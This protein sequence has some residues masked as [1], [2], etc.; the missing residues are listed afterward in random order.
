MDAAEPLQPPG[1]STYEV[2]RRPGTDAELAVEFKKRK[3]V[4]WFSPQVLANTG[5]RA[6]LSSALGDFLD[7]RELQQAMEAQALAYGSEGQEV[8]I[9]FVADTGDGFDATYSIAWLTAQRQLRID[10][11]DRPLPRAGLLVLGGDEVYPAASPTEYDN[12]FKGPYK[13]SL[14]HTQ[15]D[16]PM[17]VAIPG[18]HDWY[19]GLTN[20]MRLFCSTENEWIGGRRLVQSRSYFAIRLPNRWWIWGI[21]IQFDAYI[22]DPQVQYFK[23][24]AEEMGAGARLIL[25]TAKPSWADVEGDPQAFRNLAYLETRVIRPANVHLLVSIS[26]DSHHYARYASAEGTQK[27]TAG[28]GGAFLHPTHHLD[29]PLHVPV[30]PLAHQ[31]QEY[32]LKCRY[33]DARASR[34]LSMGALGLPFTNP[35]FLFVPGI[36]YLLLGWAS[37]FA[38]RALERGLDGPFG[39]SVERFGWTDILLGLFRNPVSVL[40]LI[41]VL[42][43]LVG[44]AKPSADWSQGRRKLVAKMA[45]GLAHFLVQLVI[46]VTV[47]LAA[48]KV[49]SFFDGTLFNIT[50]VVA[51]AVLGAVAGAL[52]MGAYLALCCAWLRTHGNEAFSSM[53]LTGYKNFLRMH[54]NR[55]G[56][57][58]IYPIGLD[59][60]N[61]SWRLDPDN[62]EPDAPWLAPD[63][64]R[65][66]C[67]LIEKPIVIKPPG[68]PIPPDGARQGTTP[69]DP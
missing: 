43:G 61:T 64:V 34:R 37:Q 42:G 22:D 33:P 66:R 44:F 47:G 55:H 45:M 54:I 67:H 50:L 36:I 52:T 30:D 56:V 53:G 20:F 27:I 10:G 7:K 68:A 13:A 9:D 4:R 63:G 5:Q 16:S 46:G 28:G 2:P 31:S 25:C 49:A 60:S 3:S 62:P 69:H 15:L 41:V 11:L 48:I 21:D 65:M 14:P 59:R 26:G 35:S 24:V 19:D 32:R 8:W 6:L 18:N 1:D 40:L 39:D 57:L 58:T 17:L 12:R 23:R 51:L 38:N 29:N